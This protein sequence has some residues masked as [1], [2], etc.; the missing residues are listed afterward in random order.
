[1]SKAKLQGEPIPAWFIYWFIWKLPKWIIYWAAI[2]MWA[3][4]TS[5]KYGTTDPTKLTI[6]EALNRWTTQ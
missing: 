1:M 4:C 6:D 5:G 2:R 3:Y